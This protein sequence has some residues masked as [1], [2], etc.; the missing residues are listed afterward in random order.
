MREN[1]DYRQRM[2]DN[3]TTAIDFLCAETGT[4]PNEWQEVDG[5]DSGVGA[6]SYFSHSDLGIWW[7]NDDQGTLIAESCGGDE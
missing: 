6:D 3:L 1:R 4:K 2:N 5:P 7:V